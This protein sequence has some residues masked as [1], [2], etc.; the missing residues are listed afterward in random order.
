MGRWLTIAEI[1]P[2]DTPFRIETLSEEEAFDL[3]QPNMEPAEPGVPAENSPFEE[4]LEGYRRLRASFEERPQ[5]VEEGAAR[6]GEVRPLPAWRPHAPAARPR[7]V[8]I[9]SSS[10]DSDSDSEADTD[11]DIEADAEMVR[12]MMRENE[13]RVA[14]R[15]SERAR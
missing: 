10:S 14:A 11:T 8:T 15:G 9:V 13:A 2:A 6:R 7:Q 1:L 3:W 4:I 12:R 5:E